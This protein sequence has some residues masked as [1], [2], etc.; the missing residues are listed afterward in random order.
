M[1]ENTYI[2]VAEDIV[3]M[4]PRGDL[5]SKPSRSPKGGSSTGERWRAARHDAGRTGADREWSP[6]RGSSTRTCTCCGVA[7]PLNA[8]T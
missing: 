8:A 6:S 7:E 5:R 4:D 3:T 2:L 1:A